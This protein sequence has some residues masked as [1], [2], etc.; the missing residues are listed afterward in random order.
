MGIKSLTSQSQAERKFS[1]EKLAL[2]AAAPAAFLMAFT[3]K[4]LVKDSGVLG[5]LVVV[6]DAA[7]VSVKFLSTSFFDESNTDSNRVTAM[8]GSSSS[9]QVPFFLPITTDRVSRTK[10]SLPFFA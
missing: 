4:S 7:S 3:T 1:R 2:E 6:V 5:A 8:Q 9:S 10:S